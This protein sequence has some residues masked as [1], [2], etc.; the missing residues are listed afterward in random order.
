MAP[1]PLKNAII[2]KSNCYKGIPTKHSY[3]KIYRSVTTSEEGQQSLLTSPVRSTHHKAGHPTDSSPTPPKLTQVPYCPSHVTLPPQEVPTRT[4]N[5]GTF[6]AASDSLHATLP[7][8]EE[9]ASDNADEDYVP[10]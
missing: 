6:S 10:V 2:T 5:H 1:S 8:D 4:T 3:R 7:T 9:E